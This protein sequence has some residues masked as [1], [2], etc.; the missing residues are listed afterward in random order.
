MLFRSEARWISE[1]GE[2]LLNLRA[3]GRNSAMSDSTK[4][5][6]SAKALGRGLPPGAIEK[7]RAANTGRAQ[8]P[9]ERRRKSAASRGQG[10]PATSL[11]DVKVRAIYATYRDSGLRQ[12]EVGAM[13]GVSQ[14]VVSAITSGKNWRHL[15]L[16]PLR[17]RTGQRAS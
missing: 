11:T 3:G 4:Q 2:A 9:E 10:N 6:I 1:Y 5:K 13:F 7:I 8:S 17:K 15:G 12:V 16:E 14:V